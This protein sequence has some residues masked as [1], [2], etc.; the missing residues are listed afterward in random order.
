MRPRRGILRLHFPSFPCPAGRCARSSSFT[1]IR[2]SAMRSSGRSGSGGLRSRCCGLLFY[3]C[4]TAG[5]RGTPGGVGGS[6]RLLLF[7]LV[8]CGEEWRLLV[9]VQVV[10]DVHWGG[11]GLLFRL[12]VHLCTKACR[13]PVL[14]LRRGRTLAT[15]PFWVAISATFCCLFMRQAVVFDCDYAIRVRFSV[16]RVSGD[17]FLSGLFT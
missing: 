17:V 11:P 13:L 3:R 8:S 14:F 9:V 1:A 5:A 2:W 15:T 10:L 7:R 4:C 6:L 12:D 16:L